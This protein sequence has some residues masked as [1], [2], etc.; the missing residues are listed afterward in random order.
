MSWWLR[1]LLL[2]AAVAVVPRERPCESDQYEVGGLCCDFCPAGSYVSRVCDVDHITECSPCEPGS[3]TAHRN[4][5]TTC[6]LCAECRE[7]Q[8]SVSD[9]T[10]DSNRRCQC[11]TGRFYCDSE[12]CVEK[13]YRCSRCDGPIL[14]TCNA[15]RDTICATGR[16]PESGD[17][18]RS[19]ADSSLV[20]PVVVP[21]SIVLIVI[22]VA[23]GIT[24]CRR[25]GVQLPHLLVRWLKHE[26]RDSGDPSQG[27]TLP[28]DPEHG[29]PSASR[30]N[31]PLLEH[32]DAARTPSEDPEG[33]VELQEVVP[34]GGRA[35]PEQALQTQAPSAPG[36]SDQAGPAAPLHALEQP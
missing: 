17:L 9:C 7:D 6:L 33:G 2:T 24:R 13:C 5:E 28:G 32:Q 22:A 35:S 10:R 12:D 15:T 1:I 34:A 26:S 18:P 11:K 31:T 8:E 20:W 25:P 29:Q 30:D 36:G 4:Q 23:I 21:I 27:G 3:F 19:H 14:E 16:N